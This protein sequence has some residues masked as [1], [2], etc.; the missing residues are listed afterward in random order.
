MGIEPASGTNRPSRPSEAAVG[1]TQPADPAA[2]EDTQQMRSWL[3][4]IV[5][6]ALAALLLGGIAA[7]WIS[8][9]SKTS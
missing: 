5:A 7:L 2:G 9:V 4:L 3:P 1:A 6:L 8:G